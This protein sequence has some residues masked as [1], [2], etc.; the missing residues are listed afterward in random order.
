[1]KIQ[2]IFEL[3]LKEYNSKKKKENAS[4]LIHKKGTLVN[5]SIINWEIPHFNE[6]KINYHNLNIR[7]YNN[8]IINGKKTSKLKVNDT[9]FTIKELVENN[10][11]RELIQ[12]KLP[13][14][15]TNSQDNSS[16][17]FEKETFSH[18]LVLQFEHGN[19]IE[20]KKGKS[21]INL[22]QIPISWTRVYKT[23]K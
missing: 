17:D 3:S 16:L 18:S 1:M 6:F 22:I 19:E 10:I 5:N 15:T 14:I 20:T 13:E 11:D 23:V 21:C 12:N 8:Q 9:K 7:T 4:V 2:D